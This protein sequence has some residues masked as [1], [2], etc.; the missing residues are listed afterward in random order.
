M[1]YMYYSGYIHDF[2]PSTKQLRKIPTELWTGCWQ[3]ISYLWPYGAIAYAY[4][5]MNLGTS[6]LSLKST[7]VTL[8][9]YFGKEDYKLLD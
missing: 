3:N 2:I 9:E 8:L 5:P 4:I 7:R 1:R 6:K